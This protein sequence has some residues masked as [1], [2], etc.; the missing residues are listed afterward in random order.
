MRKKKDYVRPQMTCRIVE[1]ESALL[2][3]SLSDDVKIYEDDDVDDNYVQ[4]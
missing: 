3:A 1:M 2:A 4:Y